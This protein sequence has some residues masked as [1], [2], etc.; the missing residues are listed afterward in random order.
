[1]RTL[2]VLALAAAA[3]LPAP[4]LGALVAIDPGHGGDDLGAVGVIPDGTDTGM[5]PRVDE[6]GRTVVYEKDITLDVAQRLEAYLRLRGETT[7]MT[8][9]GDLAGG[10]RPFTGELDDLTAR[11][12]LANAAGADLFV[13]IHQNQFTA[14][15]V[16]TETYHFYYAS[17]S[18]RAL[19]LAVHQG[20]VLRLGLPDRGV[21]SAGFY[22][23][24]HT[25]MP[26]I[27]VEG[28]FLSNGHEA[29]LMAQPVWRQRMAEGIGAGVMRYVEDQ[30]AAPADRPGRARVLV[31]RYRVTAGRYAGRQEAV[32][33]RGALRRKGIVAV[34]RR[35]YSARF[36]RNLYH[37]VAG[38]YVYLDDARRERDRLLRMGLPARV[39]AAPPAAV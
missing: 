20:V 15:S 17:R 25:R 37:V 11:V 38:V 22:V 39:D 21:R 4:A 23:L 1:M 3:A 10:D 8:R 27:L 16:G 9:T 19:A 32:R 30:Q 24:K 31:N 35:R 14:D 13:S 33:H 5:T 34:V 6:E 26:A 12:D 18:A 7:V 36:D 2:A 28:A 29:E